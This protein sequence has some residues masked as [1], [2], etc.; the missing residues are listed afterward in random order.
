MGQ[1]H[2]CGRVKMF[3]FFLSKSYVQFL[4]L[5]VKYCRWVVLFDNKNILLACNM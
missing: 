3:F 5:V 4:K 2:I 1:A